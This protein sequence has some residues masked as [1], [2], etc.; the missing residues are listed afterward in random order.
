MGR[1]NALLKTAASAGAAGNYQ[2]EL[3]LLEQALNLDIN[4]TIARRYVSALYKA[5]E[6]RSALQ[7]ANGFY[8]KD[9]LTEDFYNRINKLLQ[10]NDLSGF[11]FALDSINSFNKGPMAD[12]E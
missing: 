5:G 11:L 10:K 6:K 3:Q 4:A 12:N 1:I 2:R 7:F 8:E 9:L